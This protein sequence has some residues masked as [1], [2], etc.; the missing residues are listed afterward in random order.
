[1]AQIRVVADVLSTSPTTTPD[2]IQIRVSAKTT[3]AV[4]A[5]HTRPNTTAITGT[6]VTDRRKGVL[7][8]GV[9]STGIATKSN[10]GANNRIS[11]AG[12]QVHAPALVHPVCFPRSLITRNR[13]KPNTDKQLP[14][15]LPRIEQLAQFVGK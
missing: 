6:N 13:G 9:G 10:T 12:R 5:I 1:M 7:P 2:L 8:I 11:R 14:V 3:A 15:K 4:H